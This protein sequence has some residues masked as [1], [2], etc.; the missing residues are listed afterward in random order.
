MDS[1]WCARSNY[2]QVDERRFTKMQPSRRGSSLAAQRARIPCNF[3]AA[4]GILLMQQDAASRLSR[5]VQFKCH[6]AGRLW[7]VSRDQLMIM[8][9]GCDNNKHYRDDYSTPT[10]Y[11]LT[12]Q[13]NT[14]RPGRI[15][16]SRRLH[17]VRPASSSRVPRKTPNRLR[18]LGSDFWSCSL[19]ASPKA[20]SLASWAGQG[21]TETRGSA[22]GRLG[23]VATVKDLLAGT[24]KSS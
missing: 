12:P 24:L 1:I 11:A 13:P 17:N 3:K 23:S 15:A 5:A 8:N 2:G 19:Y 22:L 20:P 7:R 10:S 14:C 6:A 9:E 16:K 18:R 21:A 4:K